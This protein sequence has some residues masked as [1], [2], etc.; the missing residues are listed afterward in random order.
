VRRFLRIE[1]ASG[2]LLLACAVI[3][4]LLA[5]SLLG[6]AVHEFWQTPIHLGVGGWE[7]NRPLEWWINDGLM[8]VFFF[9]VGLEIKRELMTGELRTVKKAALPVIAAVGGMLVP[10][11]VY[12]LFGQSGPAQRG[13]GIPMA[14][15]IAFVVGVMTAFGQRVPFGLKI[16]LLSL[17]IA[18]D[19][20]AV[21]VIA[22]AYS[23][24][25]NLMMLVLAGGGFVLTVVLNGLGVRSVLIYSV[26]GAATWLATYHSGIHPTVSGVLLGLLTPYRAWIGQDA[27]RLAWD[28]LSERLNGRSEEVGLT[29]ADVSVLRYAAYEAVAPL[30]RLEHNL[31]PWVGFVI[32]P[33][34]ALANAGVEVKL[35]AI[36]DPVALGVAAGLLLGKPLGIVSFAWLAVRMKLSALPTGVTWPMMLAGGLLGGIGFTMSLFVAGLAF[37]GNAELLM[38]AKTGIIL[39]SV[40]AAI[41]GSTVLAMSLKSDASPNRGAA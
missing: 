4:L 6:H 33:V 29:P 27:L 18:D 24:H 38:A 17:A 1:A 2:V 25:L 3:S 12:L 8:T 40:L 15:D 22:L 13:W 41:L 10:A 21:M 5:N 35:A 14:T 34:F 11:G 7:L 28:D 37:P 23:E 26:V 9:V 19:M 36:T 32:M 31:H 30:H 39:G 16:F 20:G